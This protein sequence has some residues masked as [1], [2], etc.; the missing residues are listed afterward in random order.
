MNE[1]QKAGIMLHAGAVAIDA[2][3]TLFGYR[4]NVS[5]IGMRQ[6]HQALREAGFDIDGLRAK[7]GLGRL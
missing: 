7:E 6:L 1:Q 3:K 5:L 2:K 4:C